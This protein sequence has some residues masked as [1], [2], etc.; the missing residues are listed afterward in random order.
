[1]PYLNFYDCTSIH[2]KITKTH[3]NPRNDNSHTS[4]SSLLAFGLW[5]ILHEIVET[6]TKIERNAD[7]W[8]WCLAWLLNI[9][10]VQLNDILIPQARRGAKLNKNWYWLSTRLS[11]RVITGIFCFLCCFRYLECFTLRLRNEYFH[12]FI[13]SRGHLVFLGLL[14]IKRTLWKTL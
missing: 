5:E 12:L 6:N 13:H 11:R 14:E 10:M 9:T 1:M 8:N 3:N 2:I 7:H 4:F